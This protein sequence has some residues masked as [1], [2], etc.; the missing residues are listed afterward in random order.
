MT[1]SLDAPPRDKAAAAG[2]SVRRARELVPV[3]KERAVET[4]ALRRIPDATVAG[5]KA[6]QLHNLFTPARYGGLEL[7]W[8]VHVDVG[9]EIARGCGSTAW[10]A[11]VVL[12]NTWLLGRFPEEAQDEAW[13]ENRDLVAA[14]A[15]SGGNQLE[16]LDGGY[17]LNGL[18]RFSSG[19]DHADWVILGATLG[20]HRPHED[21]G[22][23]E[24][25]LALVKR[26]EF[27]IIDNWYAA[28]LKG[29]GS[30]D[31]KVTGQFIPEYRTIANAS[32]TMD[33]PPGARLH[34][35]YIYG[36]EFLP[37]FRS[38]LLGP[39]LGAAHGAME[40]YLS[41]TK[42]R[43]GMMFGESIVDQVPVQI[44]IAESALD[45]RCAEMLGRNVTGILARHGEEGRHLAGVKRINHV[46]D[47]AYIA[48]LCRRSVDRLASMM[49]ASGQTD[50]SPVQRHFRDVTAMAAHGSLQIDKAMSPYGRWA[51]G[52]PTG[53]AAVDGVDEEAEAY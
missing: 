21:S 30:K 15:F 6:A 51:L 39:M 43:I 25:R 4:E 41:V 28:G 17:R 22:P 16:P 29:T 1:A 40:D 19:I 38:L 45:L 42:S 7:D 13:G 10:F 27:E 37:Y 9:R 53:D 3:L 12:C 18:W 34:E 26:S 36:V 46:R 47:M 20:H 31:V 33:D 8:P 2:E 49:G 14:S 52:L 35:S 48:Q 23:P 50:N 44:R 5:L 32:S 11:T 24:F